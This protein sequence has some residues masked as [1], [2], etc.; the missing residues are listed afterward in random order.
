MN[1]SFWGEPT[2]YP[3]LVEERAE[4]EALRQRVT[5]NDPLSSSEIWRLCGLE[6]RDAAAASEPPKPCTRRSRW[7]QF[8]ELLA[9]IL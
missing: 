6:R 5:R 2:R 9:H 4:L 8:C 1:R 3:L 7:T